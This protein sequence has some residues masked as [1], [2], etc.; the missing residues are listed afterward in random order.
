[1]FAIT[2]HDKLKKL[3]PLVVVAHGAAN[4]AAFKHNRLELSSSEIYKKRANSI[5]TSIG[6]W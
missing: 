2:P 4:T 5:N 6:D 1:M 3:F